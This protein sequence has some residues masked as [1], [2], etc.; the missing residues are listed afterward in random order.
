MTTTAGVPEGA[1]DGVAEVAELVRASAARTPVGARVPW[2]LVCADVLGAA[3]TAALA[4]V[5]LPVWSPSDLLVLVVVWPA[6][7][8]ASGG[9]ASTL[10]VPHAL[11]P[12]T[13]ARAAAVL[14][15]VAWPLTALAPQLLAGSARETARSLAL[16]VVLLPALSFLLRCAVRPLAVAPVRRVV[17]AGDPAALRRVLR[18]ARLAQARGRCDMTAVAVCVDGDETTLLAGDEPLPHGTAVHRGTADLTAVVAST[19]ADVVVACPGDSI[20]HDELRRW[21]AWCQDQGVELLIGSGLRDVAPSRLGRSAIGGLHLLQVRPAHIRG[22]SHRVKDVVDRVAG[23]LLLVLVAPALLALVVLVRRD[24]PGPALYRQVR[25]GTDGRPFTVL[26]LRT[27]CA[28]AD[29]VRTGLG[30]ANESDRSGVLF[31]I[32]H[33]PRITRLGAV[34]RRYSLDEL[35]QLINVAR[36]EMS[37]IGPRPALPAEVEAYPADLR[38]R[39]AVKPGLTGL[40]QVSGRSDLS[41]EETVRLDLEYVDNWSWALDARIAV[42]TVKAVLGHEGAY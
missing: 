11:R 9:F 19:G 39:L 32:R 18:E 26:K 37:L 16:V 2:A 20:G 25:V 36:G 38:R 14:A 21:A 7:V 41:W 13:L 34:L 12:R 31:K 15:L 6:L 33:D 42:R 4:G 8:A 22:V 28:D 5:L 35:P 30:E 3:G 29:R 27:M 1:L 17:L 23:T 40:W 24:S 10:G